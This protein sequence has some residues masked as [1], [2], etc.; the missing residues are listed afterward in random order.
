MN[1]CLVEPTHPGNIGG[2]ARALK[3]MGF[4][5][6]S[7]V[8]PK[9]FPAEEATAMAAGAKD[10]LAQTQ[11][12][13]TLKEALASSS[14]VFGTSARSRSIAWPLLNPREAAEKAQALSKHG[15][16]SFVFGRESSGLS[17]EELALC[18]YHV[19]IPSN[20]EYSSLN[21]AQ[22]VQILAY[23]CRMASEMPVSKPLDEPL[24]KQADLEVWIAKIEEQCKASGFLKAENPRYLL[25]RIRRLLAKAEVTQQEWNMLQGIIKTYG[26]R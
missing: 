17:N 9:L 21:L 11:V 25:P 14:V 22:A 3:T 13:R 10:V 19:H 1:F 5:D 2:S 7:L 18:Q 20:P 16:V 23:E 12:F 24:V 26:N 6:L 15:R 8:S 4:S